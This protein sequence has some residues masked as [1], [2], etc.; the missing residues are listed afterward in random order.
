MSTF[1]L[2]YVAWTF[3]VAMGMYAYGMRN[4]TRAGL[5][6]GRIQGRTELLAE[7]DR[8]RRAAKVDP[9]LRA[10]VKRWGT[11]P[12]RIRDIEF[13]DERRDPNKDNPAEH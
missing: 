7:Q 9:T 5:R 2:L 10:E 12:S 3:I 1:D 6:R 11:R 4:G 13:I 8:Q